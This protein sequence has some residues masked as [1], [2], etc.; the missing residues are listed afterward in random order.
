MN[1]YFLII[2]WFPFA[3]TA[4]TNDGGTGKT[5]PGAA[6]EKLTAGNY[7]DAL[8]DYLALHTQDP[9]NE[10]YA[11]NLAVCYLNYN[12]N[13]TKA[14]PYLE[15]LTHNVKHEANADFLLG[16]AYQYALRFDDAIAA[17]NRFTKAG[18]GKEENLKDAELQIQYCLNAKERLKFPLNVTFENLGKSVNSEY[19]DYYAFV[20]LDESF[21]IY[22]S[23]RPIGDVEQK[24]NGEYPTVILYSEVKGGKY[25]LAKK[26]EVELPKGNANAEV[27]GLSANGNT[28]LLYIND[29]KGNGS[30]YTSEHVADNKF[31]KPTMLD[32]QIN[33]PNSE[34]IAA[35][36]SA[37]GDVIYF[38]S[39]RVG[40]MG[41]T[42]IYACRKTP[43]GAWGMAMNLGKGI[44]TVQ[45]EDFPNIS[46]DGKELYFSS[47]GH[48][49]MGGYDIFKAT[50]NEETNAWEN[51]KNIGYPVNTPLD[52]YNFRVS[53]SNRYGYISAIRD[54]GLGDFDNY[55][56]TFNDVEP[57]LSLMYGQVLSEDGS[58]I[59]FPD[60]LITVNN[61]KSGELI[62]TYLPNP[63]TGKYVVILPPGKYSLV[64]ELFDFKLLTKK[65]EIL[66]KASFQSEMEIDLKL[67]IQ[68]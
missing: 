11:Y 15:K 18:K 13:K 41:G 25:Q 4:Q 68:K 40:G 12:G 9:Q 62:G 52:D 16:R 21:I 61:D 45:N 23:K 37:E 24:P 3:L 39:D 27:I 35:S 64:V 55:R 66:D 6:E 46:P 1:K 54:E 22:N 59:N 63:K 19:N 67:Q 33:A 42:D 26:L 32:K 2:L 65:L 10:K 50:K 60:V 56:I 30:I 5:S 53:K 47:T 36:I 17:F 14:V 20:P 7:E 57:E 58:Q 34:E 44:N 38:A 48:S 28:L 49:S 43:A 8:V 29:N 31:A 51:P